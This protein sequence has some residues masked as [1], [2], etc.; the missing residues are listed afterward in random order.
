MEVTVYDKYEAVIGLEVH[1]QLLTKSKIYSADSTEYGAAPNTQISPI[2]LAMPGVLPKLNK[3]VVDMAIKVGLALNC[4]ITEVNEFARKHYFYADLPKGYQITQDKTPICTHGQIEIDTSGTKKEIGITRIHMEEDA[5]KNNHELDPFYSLIDLNRAGM[6]LIEIVSEPDIRT[7]DEAYSY[8][9]ELRKLLRYLDVCDGNMEEGSMRCD[10]NIS[11][12]LRGNSTF[13]TRVEVKNMNSIRNVKR[14]IDSEI[15]RQIDLIES[16]AEVLQQTRGFNPA[17]GSTTP[18][19]SKELANDYRYFPEPDLPP[20]IV[21]QNRVNEVKSKMPPLPSE[22]LEKFTTELGLSTYDARVLTDEKDIA[23][24]FLELISETNNYK[25][26]AN[27]IMGEVKSYLNQNA[28]E[29]KDFILQPRHILSIIELVD[30]GLVS[31]SGAKRLFEAMLE[32][33][34]VSAVDLANQLNLIQNS[35]ID[36]LKSWAEV[37]LL[38]YPEKVLEY[39]GGKKG[40]LG[41]FMGEV[42]KI[43]GGQADPKSTSKIL[44]ELLDS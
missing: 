18:L 9:T 20:V 38:K 43:S 44:Q 4:K 12:R 31:S 6:P 41:L 15:K 36:Q 23:L 32:Q 40:I 27:W 17:D 16:G 1:A 21:K 7:S 25:A 35:N 14:A 26:A 39:R 22:L 42:M 8:L 34:D 19:R 5:G 24:Y 13:G 2:T 37:A 11:V 29:I 28:I 33:P 3:E 30:K 10:A